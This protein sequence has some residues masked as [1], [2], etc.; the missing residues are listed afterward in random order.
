M[1]LFV[2]YARS[3]RAEVQALVELLEKAGHELWFDFLLLPGQDWKRIL[4]GQIKAADVLIYAMSEYSLASEWCRW[5]ASQA[6]EHDKPILPLMLRQIEI[7]QEFSH[8]HIVPVSEQNRILGGLASLS[9][10]GL[11]HSAPSLLTPDSPKGKPSRAAWNACASELT[12]HQHISKTTLVG[13]RHLATDPESVRN[14]HG[15]YIIGIDF[16]TSKS[17]CSI[18]AGD[19]PRLI[20]NRYG[21]FTTPSAVYVR[22]DHSIL[23]GDAA[24]SATLRD[25]QH[26]VLQVKR[27][28]GLGAQLKAYGKTWSA[29]ELAAE[30]FKSLAADV[31]IFLGESTQKVVVAA[32]AY[33]TE[34]QNDDLRQACELAGLILVSIIAEPTAASLTFGYRGT[35]NERLAVV[36]LGG[37]TFDIS[38]LEVGEKVFEVLAIDG[39]SELGGTDY[40][41][42]LVDCCVESFR[43]QTGVNLA[44]NLGARMRIRDAAEKAKIELTTTEISYIFVPF[45]FADAS[46]A[47]DLSVKIT[48]DQFNGLTE[49]LTARI[50]E[51]CER[52]VTSSKIH[53]DRILLVGLP[54]RTPMVVERLSCYFRMNPSPG[55]NPET[56]VAE[57]AAIRAGILMNEIRDLLLLDVTPHCL[58]LQ[59]EGGVNCP[60]VQAGTT[61]PTKKIELF[62]LT[63]PDRTHVEL[64]ILQGESKKAEESLLLSTF[65]LELGDDV[66]EN[67]EVEVTFDVDTNLDL[68]IE[69][70]LI[71]TNQARKINLCQPIFE[72]LPDCAVGST[73]RLQ[74]QEHTRNANLAADCGR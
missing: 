64:R 41:E 63:S 50:L 29:A 34:A 33:F 62:S 27:L 15:K 56:C 60:I 67:P 39:E 18:W 38:I 46:G 17:L 55:L 61:I 8:L 22:N 71:N 13:Q 25:P 32:P 28:F 42:A 37:G 53:I 40:D 35:E 54:T 9:A 69:A 10:R 51:C 2:S 70:K 52:A 31:E 68:T 73:L 45:I 57:G 21:S 72:R 23:V 59:I 43:E 6:V 74:N 11:G 16:G 20:P 19:A 49:H 44:G 65:I 5:E 4:A 1:K 66:P 47:I 48:R 30:V 12:P 26:G 3:D 36:D 58:G 7:P 14:N 24:V